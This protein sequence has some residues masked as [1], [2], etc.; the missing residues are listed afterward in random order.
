MLL[1]ISLIY[2]IPTTPLPPPP[3]VFLL[4]FPSHPDLLPSVSPQIRIGLQGTTTKCGIASNSKTRHI[5]PGHGNLVG[6]KG[7]YK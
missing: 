5:R 7:F 2:Y 4:P 1:S 6:G 3:P